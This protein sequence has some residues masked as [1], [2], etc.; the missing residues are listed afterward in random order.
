MVCAKACHIFTLDADRTSHAGTWSAFP[1]ACEGNCTDIDYRRLTINIYP[2]TGYRIHPY[3]QTGTGRH[4]SHDCTCNHD[5]QYA[6]L[7]RKPK[8]RHNHD[9]HGK[10]EVIP[11]VPTS[12]YRK[13][14]RRFELRHLARYRKE[15]SQHP[16]SAET[17]F[18]FATAANRLGLYDLCNSELKCAEYL[19]FKSS[20]LTRVK[21]KNRAR[22]SD[23][24]Q[25]DTNQFQRFSILQT[26]LDKLLNTGDSI[27]DI[28]GGHGILSQFMPNNRYFLVEPS[29]NGISGLNLPFQNG[30]FD[31]V[32]TCHVLEHIAADARTQFIDELIRVS[33]KSVLIFNPFRNSE[34]DELER[35]KLILEVTNADWAKEHL[36]CGLPVL[37]ETTGY[38]S[39]KGLAYTT[40]GY[41][42]IYA[43]LATTFMS[44][45]AEKQR[46]DALGRINQHL[47][48]SYNQ[49]GSGA[50][51]SNMM[52]EITLDT[53]TSR[54]SRANRTVVDSS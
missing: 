44:Y 51:P 14:R 52:I 6:V 12:A 16:L 29:V 10:A 49:L 33:R 8:I 9:S 20:E 48:K 37:E 47:N 36:E 27:L 32:V 42:D 53:Q 17:H 4:S 30:C 26:H 15:L 11:T 22:L 41:G 19:G 2:L 45:F 39:S 23:P 34:L 3:E 1:M 50:Y 25:L 40:T 31:A 54:N 46:S 5:N 43:A 28:G 7:F 24:D 38:L 21:L 35:L 13:L 18:E